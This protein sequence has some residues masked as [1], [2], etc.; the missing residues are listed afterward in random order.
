MEESSGP[1][2]LGTVY[3]KR[4]FLFHHILEILHF[5]VHPLTE[6]DSP[7][8]T[9]FISPCFIPPPF[10]RDPDP[11]A[12]RQT[13]FLHTFRHP[14]PFFRFFSF[15]SSLLPFFLTVSL[16]LIHHLYHSAFRAS[17]FPDVF[18]LL[19]TYFIFIFCSFINYYFCIL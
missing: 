2:S 7:H 18:C 12:S 8:S 15:F 4:F 11:T 9:Y 17:L 5:S 14:L 16:F 1:E 6:R 3:G 10:P 19:Y 13:R